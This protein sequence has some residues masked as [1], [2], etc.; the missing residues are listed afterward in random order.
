LIE[1]LEGLGKDEG[2]GE[3]KSVVERWDGKEGNGA[4]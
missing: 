4:N 3:G 1:N 2:N